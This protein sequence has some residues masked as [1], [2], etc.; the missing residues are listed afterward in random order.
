ML[1]NTVILP[2]D[3]ILMVDIRENG[4][5]L[6]CVTT[7][8]NTR[9]CNDGRDSGKWFFPDGSMVDDGGYRG[10]YTNTSNQ[11]ITLNRYHGSIMP[12]GVYTCEVSGHSA[13][14]SILLR[15]YDLYT[16]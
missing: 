6:A 10:F 15:G 16:Y 3:S 14:V 8:V 12:F 9:C 11:R 7:N 2:G 5:S 1:N 13:N 4:H